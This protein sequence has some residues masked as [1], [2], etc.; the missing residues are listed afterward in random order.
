MASAAGA[1]GGVGAASAVAGARTATSAPAAARSVSEQ[2]NVPRQIRAI[3]QTMF[4][5]VFAGNVD[6]MRIAVARG[7]MVNAVNELGRSALQ[8]ARERNDSAMVRALVELG[9]K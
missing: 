3:D 5:A 7:A 6:A 4:E 2:A 9:A 8:V 1:A